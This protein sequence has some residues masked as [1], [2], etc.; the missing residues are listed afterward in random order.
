MEQQ[1]IAGEEVENI[2]AQMQ[3]KMRNIEEVMKQ[4]GERAQAILQRQMEARRNRRK[5][6]QEK[7]ELAEQNIVQDEK[8]VQEAKDEVVN[9][10]QEELKEE[11]DVID[12]EQK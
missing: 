2:M 10:L 11:I 9:Q 3:F 5:A 1:G 4:D 6:L 12:E 8:M 7:L